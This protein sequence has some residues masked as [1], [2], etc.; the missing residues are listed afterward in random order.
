M[1]IHTIWRKSIEFDIKTRLQ[2]KDRNR[3]FWDS[4]S[5]ES[6]KRHTS[7]SFVR[8]RHECKMM[9]YGKKGPGKKGPGKNGPR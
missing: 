1:S 2:T 7:K 3:R 6:V 5:R 9:G 8:W 4:N